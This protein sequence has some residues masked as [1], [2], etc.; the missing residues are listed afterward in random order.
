[1]ALAQKFGGSAVRFDRLFDRQ[2]VMG[3][4]GI[5]LARRIRDDRRGDRNIALLAAVVSTSRMIPLSL[6]AAICAL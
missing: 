1:M 2:R 4:V 6:S 3:A 5:D